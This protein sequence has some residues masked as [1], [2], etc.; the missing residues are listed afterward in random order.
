MSSASEDIYYTILHS[1]F[2][3]LTLGDG[4]PMMVNVSHI[5]H[6]T[7]SGTGTHL[8]ILGT[9]E[10]YKVMENMNEIQSMVKRSRL[11]DMVTMG[12]GKA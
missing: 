4:L 8:H 11:A 6:M 12:G 10:V 2:I 7:P 3:L 1:G 5:T 9:T